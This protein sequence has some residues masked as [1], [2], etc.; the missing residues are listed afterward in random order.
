[1]N[2]RKGAGEYVLH[3]LYVTL[4]PLTHLSYADELVILIHNIDGQV[5]V[6]VLI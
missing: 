6:I 1:V 3:W 4:F 2:A 5:I